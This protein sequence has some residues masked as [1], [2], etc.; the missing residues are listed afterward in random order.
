MHKSVEK[1]DLDDEIDQEIQTRRK[2]SKRGRWEN[3]GIFVLLCIL[4]VVIYILIPQLCKFDELKKCLFEING[5]EISWKRIISGVAILTPLV[6][7][8]LWC[9][10]RIVANKDILSKE[11][12]SLSK[13]E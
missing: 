12:Y 4:T 1:K 11:Y 5:F 7:D 10:F 9:W 6:I 3:I 2:Q 8:A 13:A